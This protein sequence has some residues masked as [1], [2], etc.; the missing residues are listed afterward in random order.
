MT[1][2]TSRLFSL[3]NASPIFMIAIVI[4]AA[5]PSSRMGKPKQN[6]LFGK[7]TLLQRTILEAKQVTDE[8]LVTL[9]ANKDEILP[10]LEGLSVNIFDNENW[11][12]GIATSITSAVHHL[13]SSN[14]KIAGI[15]FLLCDQPFVGT[16]LLKELTKVARNSENGIIASAYSGTIGVPVYFKKKYFPELLKLKGQEG[17][18]KLIET[19]ASDVQ[20]VPFPA[21]GIDIDTAKDFEKL[22]SGE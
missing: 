12:D 22:L 16:A 5:G 14:D 1:A 6:L 2:A 20:T 7:K 15:I 17:A 11:G 8:V 3:F 4:L 13:S 19:F 9:G 21:G 18:K 10:T